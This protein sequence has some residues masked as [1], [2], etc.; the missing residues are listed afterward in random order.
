MQFLQDN[1]A[2]G[3]Y[4]AACNSL[5]LDFETVNGWEDM[6]MEGHADPRMLA[7]MTLPAVRNEIPTSSRRPCWCNGTG[8]LSGRFLSKCSTYCIG[9]CQQLRDNEDI[10]SIDHFPIKHCW[11]FLAVQE[12]IDALIHP[13]FH[14][15]HAEM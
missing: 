4:S 11:A 3:R 8:F 1:T 7:R 9:V 14:Q 12:L 15:E 2:C 13:L 10:D 6:I 5:Q